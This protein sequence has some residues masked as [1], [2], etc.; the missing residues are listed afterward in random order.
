ML[1]NEIYEQLKTAF[2][3]MDTMA[4]LDNIAIRIRRR[5]FHSSCFDGGFIYPLNS[6]KA[7]NMKLQESGARLNNYNSTKDKDVTS[8][9]VFHYYTFENINDT[10][11]SGVIFLFHGLNEKKWDKYLP[12]AYQLS[13]L[14]GKTVI[15]FP[16]AFHMNRAPLAWSNSRLMQKLAIERANK[17]TN[18]HSSF[19][20]AALSERLDLNPQRFFWSGF[21]TYSDFCS[22]I[23]IIRCGEVSNISSNATIDLFGYSIGAFFSWLLMMD[24]PENMLTNSRLFMFCGGA[25]YDKTYPISKFIVDKR[26]SSSVTSF[27]D[28]LF[29]NTAQAEKT[30]N[31]YFEKFVPKKSHFPGIMNYEKFKDLR[32]KRLSQIYE[33]INVVV[34]KKD[35]VF[36][37]HE[38]MNSLRG[39]TGA[40]KISVDVIDF[41]YPYNHI[42]PFPLSGKY[43]LAVDKSFK[44]VMETASIFLS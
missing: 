38:V 26:A 10:I 2:E 34:L 12:W 21:Q 19:A 36:L 29:Q 13:K 4:E 30:I 35:D 1:Y 6:E 14:T 22:L 41:D 40:I 31:Y 11:S 42:T 18:S 33:Q 8:N 15:L 43:N 3:K 7:F 25:T 20:N 9:S 5:E 28:E 44:S 39:E 37:P 16:I 23:K 24:N 27:F 32:E 17:S